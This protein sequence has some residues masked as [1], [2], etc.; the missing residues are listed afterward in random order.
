MANKVITLEGDFAGWTCELRESISARI[1][2]DLESGNPSKALSAFAQIVV[3]HNFKGLDGEP[4]ES[5]LDA[6]IRALTAVMEKWG[7]QQQ[8]DPK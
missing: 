2:I 8:L 1:L 6:D 4:V 7:Q 5:V 3:S